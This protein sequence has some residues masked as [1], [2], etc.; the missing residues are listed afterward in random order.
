MYDSAKV[1]QC[2]SC[3]TKVLKPAG[4]S[5]SNVAH[6]LVDIQ[7]FKRTDQAILT[8]SAAQN[9][10]DG[11]TAVCMWACGECIHIANVGD[12]K[13]VLA[14]GTTSHGASPQPVVLGPRCC[15]PQAPTDNDI[16]IVAFML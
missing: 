3:A 11:S 1:F 2:S 15:M 16:Y 9:W 7:G 12:A 14:R 4:S 8:E 6:L 10:Q 5:N 13:A